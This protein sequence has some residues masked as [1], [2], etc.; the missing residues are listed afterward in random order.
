[1][2]RANP[3]PAY[4]EISNATKTYTPQPVPTPPAP[5]QQKLLYTPT[6]AA[7]NDQCFID[8]LE[9]SAFEGKTHEDGV[10]NEETLAHATE[11]VNLVLKE[12]FTIE[13]NRARLEKLRERYETFKFLIARPEVFWDR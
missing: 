11:V 4:I 9:D 6:W 8:A 1:M 3:F 13:Q 2:T 10:V 12:A 7:A 5:R